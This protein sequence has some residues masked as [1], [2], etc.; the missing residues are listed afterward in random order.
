M[1]KKQ[2]DILF[3]YCFRITEDADFARQAVEVCGG[4]NLKDAYKKATRLAAELRGHKTEDSDEVQNQLLAWVNS[5]QRLRQLLSFLD[6]LPTL[7]QSAFV[8]RHQAEMSMRAIADYLD[9]DHCTVVYQIMEAEKILL[10]KM[11]LRK[12]T[13]LPAMGGRPF[14]KAVLEMS[15]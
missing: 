15:S 7:Q 1:E 8:M 4:M 3:N 2:Q 11:E 10:S 9:I 14:W 12:N 6:A 13:P 5:Q